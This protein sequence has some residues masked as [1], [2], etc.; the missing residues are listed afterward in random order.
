MLM[1][2]KNIIRIAF[3]THILGTYTSSLFVGGEGEWVKYIHYL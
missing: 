3:Q 1:L 2:T